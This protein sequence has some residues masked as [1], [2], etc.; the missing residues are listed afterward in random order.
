MFSERKFRQARRKYRANQEVASRVPFAHEGLAVECCSRPILASKL[1][2]TQLQ[3]FSYIFVTGFRHAPFWAGGAV[4]NPN[5]TDL[6]DQGRVRG[7]VTDPRSK[8]ET[9]ADLRGERN[10]DRSS[11]TEEVAQCTR[12][13]SQLVQTRNRLRVG[14]TGIEAKCRRIVKRIH[15]CR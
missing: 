8:S 3:E 4:R 14:A 2:K 11:G 5:R 13:N 9:H 15:R 1:L 12:R 6:C 7:G 10:A